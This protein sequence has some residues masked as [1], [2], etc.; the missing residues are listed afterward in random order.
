[1]RTGY[2]MQKLTAAVVEMARDTNSLQSRLAYAVMY[3]L[4]QLTT[5]DFPEHLQPEFEYI[6]HESTKIVPTGDEGAVE[7]STRRMPEIQI[8]Q[9]I[10]RIVILFRETAKVAG[11]NDAID[12]L[13]EN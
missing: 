6:R 9:L 13:R 4:L 11:G 12:L 3:G 8:K 1:M 5:E 2:V 10:E 7:A